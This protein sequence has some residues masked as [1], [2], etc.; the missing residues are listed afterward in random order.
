M[1]VHGIC[2][3]ISCPPSV[4]LR[5]P[6]RWC[7]LSV[8]PLEQ[9]RQLELV[10]YVAKNTLIEADSAVPSEP[11]RSNQISCSTLH[12]LFFPQNVLFLFSLHTYMRSRYTYIHTSVKVHIYIRSRYIHKVKVHTYVHTWSTYIR[13]R[14]IHTW[15]T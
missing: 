8:C 10:L 6:L 7:K 13:S 15:F 9:F 5:L 1:C 14:Y 11:E 2:V 3:C 12:L 4:L